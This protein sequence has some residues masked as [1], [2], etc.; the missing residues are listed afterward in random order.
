MEYAR[1]V[2]KYALLAALLAVLA[3]RPAPAQQ[4]N[5]SVSLR[6][7]GREVALSPAL[8][9]TLAVLARQILSRCGPNTRNHAD[10]FGLAAFTVE[11]RWQ[12]LNAGSR[13]RVLF[14]EPFKSESHL[15]GSLGVSEAL[16]G[17]EQKDL[18][19]GPDFTR[20]GSAIAEHLRC[21]YLP[22]L[23]LACL[24]E[25]APHLPAAYRETC[26]KMERDAA[27]RIV[28]PPPDIAPSCS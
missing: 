23:E 27:G 1:R 20:Y 25:L 9:G 12:Q 11:R 7:G 22:S 13:L 16:I 17:L 19:V 18:F 6:L 5:D 4:P 10:N 21:D 24:A 14:A 15:G 8:S 2:K 3:Q 28:M 26:A